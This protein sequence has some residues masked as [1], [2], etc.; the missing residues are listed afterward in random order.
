MNYPIEVR[1][2]AAEVPLF[3]YNQLNTWQSL[4]QGRE[5]DESEAKR[6]MV[7]KAADQIVHKFVGQLIDRAQIK[8]F[9]EPEGVAVRVTCVALSYDE[10]CNLLYR[11]YAEGQSDGMRRNITV[12]MMR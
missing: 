6:R 4:Y 11:A 1:K 3:H 8:T 10:L 5:I 9:E 7:F 12:E 2:I